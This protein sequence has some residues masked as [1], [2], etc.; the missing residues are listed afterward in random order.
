M[1][2]RERKE[3]EGR[4]EKKRERE[5]KTYS[6]HGFGSSEKYVSAMAT[7]DVILLLGSMTRNL[8]SCVAGGHNNFTNHKY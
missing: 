1:R 5:F 3:R 8:L 4:G 7:S 6:V 2:G